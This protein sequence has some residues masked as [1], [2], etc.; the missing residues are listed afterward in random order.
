MGF[1]GRMLMFCGLALSLV[2]ASPQAPLDTVLERMRAAAGMSDRAHVVSTRTFREGGVAIT[3]RDETQGLQ[4]LMQ[5]CNDSICFG[6]YFDGDRLYSV[7]MNGTSLPRSVREEVYVRG[8][9]VVTGGE[10]LEPAFG[11]SGGHIEDRGIAHFDSRSYRRMDVTATDAV[12]MEVYVDPQTWLVAMTRDANEDAEFEFHDYRRVGA[13]RLPFAIDRDGRPFQRYTSRTV[14][15]TPLRI[16]SGLV[17][18]L[19]SGGPL[20]L[21]PHNPSPVGTCTIAGV[22]ARCLIDTGNSGISMSLELA[23]ELRAPVVGAFEV[24]G[25]GHYATEVVSAGPLRVGNATFQQA[26]YVV[27]HDIHAYGYDLVLGADVLANARLTIDYAQHTASFADPSRASEATG[28]PLTFANFV[29]IVP[30]ELGALQTQLAVD[31]GDQSAINLAYDY[32]SEHTGLFRATRR[33]S[34]EGVGGTSIE[35]LGEIPDARIGNF[36]VASPG[37]GTTQ[38]LTG[39]SDGHIGTG[40]LAHFRVVIDYAARRLLLFARRGDTSVKTGP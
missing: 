33:A 15:P 23:E 13:Y 3:A 32:Y 18:A 30:V 8:L 14:V 2:G 24:N 17:P 28:I 31:T 26:K 20:A 11:A 10:F 38:T 22:Q 16:P 29:P 25:L 19:D 4:A 7:N 36:T 34:V 9:R 12:P 39:T 5:R 35:L 1:A 6:T 37:I 40:F 21:D 27:L